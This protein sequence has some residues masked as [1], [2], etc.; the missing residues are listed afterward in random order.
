MP[1]GRIPWLHCLR[2]GE[3]TGGSVKTGVLEPGADAPP[4]PDDAVGRER[5]SSGDAEGPTRSWQDR[6]RFTRAMVLATAVAA[7]PFLWLLW[8]PWE[9]PNPLRRAISQTNFYDLQTRAMFHGH[10]WVANGRLGVEAF[11]HG[12]RQYTYFG[13]F[14]SLVRVPV[15]LVT[16]TLDGRLTAPFMLVAWLFTALF[17]SLLFWRLRILIRG[18]APLGYAETVSLG[19]LVATILGGS[20]FLILAVTP[21]VYNEDLAWSICLTVG[22]LFA[23]LGVLE[24]P[25]WG[26][27]AASGTLA[28]A[29][30]LDRVTTG[31]ACVVAA[32][33]IGAWF[34]LGRGGRQNQRWCL[35]MVAVGVVPL[36]A[37]AAVNY[38]KFGTLFGLPVTDQVYSMVNVYR[39]KFLAA[40]HFSEVGTAFA[41]T[42]LLAYLRLDGL[43][44]TS[45]FPF[46]TLPAAPN[47]TLAAVLFDKRYRTAS[48]PSS[49]PLLFLLGVWGTVTAFRPRPVGKVALTRFLLL[50]AGVACAALMLWGYIAPRYLADFMPFLVL[51]SGIGMVDVWRRMESRSRPAR[52][53]VTGIVAFAALFTAMA[54]IGMAS[55]PN[56][57]WNPVQVLHY[58]EAQQ[59]VSNLTGH[60]L[61]ANVV[62]GNSLPPDG[63]AD[64]L[65]IVGDCDG[66]YI[67]NGENYTTVPS[68]SFPRTTWMTVERGHRF[69]HT[70]EMTFHQPRSGAPGFG[71]VS[72]G[73]NTVAVNVVSDESHG[74]VR[75]VFSFTSPGHKVYGLTPYVPPGTTHRVQVVTDPAKH[76]V[77]VSMDGTAYLAGDLTTNEPIVV[78]TEHAHS[79]GNPPALAVTNITSSTPQPSLCHQLAGSTGK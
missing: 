40:N 41:P 17:V 29:A 27:V 11:V 42:D 52:V 60:T 75:V 73:A 50:S 57:Q 63:P 76:Q 64:R 6:R 70:F 79:G 55:T 35:P 23:L 58:V 77:L 2:M 44:F 21:Y 48:L 69:L 28:L 22:A 14:P 12:G 10:L 46:I 37:A 67:S 38:A 30:N 34:G 74:L 49:M 66:L 13:L 24:R 4:G 25:G 5:P 39:H 53:T 3:A 18:V 26:R 36:I 8:G 19:L 16:S 56:E 72:A 61:D 54:N 45:V 65:F 9:S 68:Q 51:A 1:V 7:V 47:P 78:D 43:R 33:L 59:A 71:L 32:V 31:Y 20:V 62:R 15:L